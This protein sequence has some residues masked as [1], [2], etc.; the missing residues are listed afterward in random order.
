LGW[1]KLYMK[2]GMGKILWERENMWQNGVW[3]LAYRKIV[4]LIK[5]NEGG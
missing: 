3:K 4:N 1:I 2:D 5:K